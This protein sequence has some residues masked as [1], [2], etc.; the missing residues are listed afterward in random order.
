MHTVQD[1][2]NYYLTEQKDTSSLEDLTQTE[3]LPPNLHVN[4]EYNRFDPQT[5]TFFE[6]KDAFPNRDTLTPS[7][8][9]SKKYKPVIKPKEM[10]NK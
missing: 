7:L 4:L 6:G 2:I 1:V 9:Y 8:W 10:F 3:N 5:D